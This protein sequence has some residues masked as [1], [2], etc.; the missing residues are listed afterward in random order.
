[1]LL[2][3]LSQDQNHV[4]LIME[5]ARTRVRYFEIL[6]MGNEYCTICNKHSTQFIQAKSSSQAVA[7]TVAQSTVLLPANKLLSTL[8]I[9]LIP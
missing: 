1:M 9:A 6:S 5:K 2:L 8:E 4:V 3:N 7:S